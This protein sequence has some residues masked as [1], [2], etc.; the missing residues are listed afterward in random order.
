M[1]FFASRF[2]LTCFCFSDVGFLLQTTDGL[3]LAA[4][5]LLW[6]TNL[7]LIDHQPS[8]LDVKRLSIVSS[9]I[10]RRRTFKFL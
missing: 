3:F 10:I 8:L 4:P 6:A 9:I 7:Q 5:A 2:L 1:G